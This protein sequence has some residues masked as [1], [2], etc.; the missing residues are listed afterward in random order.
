M[1]KIV[2]RLIVEDLPYRQNVRL[3]GKIDDKTFFVLIGDEFT[4]DDY[5]RRYDDVFG[6]P[7][8]PRDPQIERC[9]LKLFI[10]QKNKDMKE[11][12]LIKCEYYPFNPCKETIIKTEEYE[13]FFPAK[14][15]FGA[16]PINYTEKKST[17]SKLTHLTRTRKPATCNGHPIEVLKD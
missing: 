16:D 4:L 6:G 11:I 17:I 3:W 9:Q 13:F 14:L 8:R 7:R 15:L 12:P 10:G 2:N 5:T 1:T